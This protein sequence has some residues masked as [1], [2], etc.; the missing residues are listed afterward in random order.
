MTK[1]D[2]NY[3]KT[4]YLNEPFK[5]FRLTDEKKI[6]IDF[7]YHDFHKILIHITGNVSYCIEGRTYNLLPNDI[8]FVNAGEVHRPIINDSTP[9]QRIIIYISN[10]FL[11]KYSDP[12]NDISLCFK[13]TMENQSRVLRLPAISNT[14][15]EHAI[16]ELSN[17]ISD[18]E[19]A[20][21]LHQEIL[22]LEFMIQLNRSISSDENSY[23]TTSYS[24][25]KILDVI[26]YLNLNLT[27]DLSI[28][29]IAKEFYLSRYY[30]MHA[31][32]EE[33]GYSIGNYISTKRLLLAKE[34]IAGG[35]TVSQAC[36]DC[37]FKN[38]STFA[39]AYKKAFNSSPLKKSP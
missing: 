11:D 15:L 26:N 21:K 4:G 6:D 16:Y 14:K 22:F 25:Q 35:S 31:F 29:K 28:D 39:R 13:R 34:L 7:H 36:Y 10:D 8:V 2:K 1:L 17:S 18:T 5:V 20:N 33:T 9:Y 38:Y 37:G 3:E 23:L 12:Q 27:N 32:K 19:Y 30:L 24:N